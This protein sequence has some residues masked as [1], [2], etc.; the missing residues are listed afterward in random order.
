[1]KPDARFFSAREAEDKT[2]GI[3][4]Y[5][6]GGDKNRRFKT[7]E[8]RSRTKNRQETTFRDTQDV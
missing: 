7:T 3:D 2:T 1:M 4:I 5:R 6:Q 8:R